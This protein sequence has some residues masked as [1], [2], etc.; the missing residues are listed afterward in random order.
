MDLSV[1]LTG[2]YVTHTNIDI[3]YTRENRDMRLFVLIS[4]HGLP[5]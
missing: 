1:C 3:R 5:G 4:S 2:D